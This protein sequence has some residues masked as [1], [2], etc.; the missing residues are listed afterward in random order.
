MEGRDTLQEQS[1]PIGNG[2]IGANIWLDD[3]G[4]IHALISH[5]EAL[6]EMGR[7]VKVG[8]LEIRLEAYG[9]DP[10]RLHLDL[11]ADEGMVFLC[12]GDDPSF[13]GRLWVDAHRPCIRF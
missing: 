6:S 7:L 5:N 4:T 11:D 1:L 10:S 9:L 2:Y 13:L 12:T 8:H 3:A